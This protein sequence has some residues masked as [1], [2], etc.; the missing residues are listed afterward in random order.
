L[1]RLPFLSQLLGDKQP[2]G[3]ASFPFI[4]VGM[5]VN[6]YMTTCLVCFSQTIRGSQLAGT[7]KAILATPTS[8]ATFLM[9]SSTYPFVRAS[10][11]AVVYT[12]AGMLF[13]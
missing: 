9:C 10:L 11:D 3:Y 1:P 6:A 2:D 13:G 4:L 7:L 8:P 5:T 12:T